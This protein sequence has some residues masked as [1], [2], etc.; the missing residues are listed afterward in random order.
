MLTY[1]SSFVFPLQFRVEKATFGEQ[2]DKGDVL[3][4]IV[5]VVMVV[6]VDTQMGA[7]WNVWQNGCC[8]CWLEES[9]YDC[10]GW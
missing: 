9:E 5:V 7:M 3:E 1:F 4:A 6:V 2:G 10:A 8:S